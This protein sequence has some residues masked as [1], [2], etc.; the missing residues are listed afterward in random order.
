[1]VARDVT[2]RKHAEQEM[3]LNQRRLQSLLRISQYESKDV[4]ELLDYALDEALA[5]T[6]STIGWFGSYDEKT[7]T[8]TIQAWSKSVIESCGLRAKPTVF[9][10]ENAGIWAEGIRGRQPFILN[11]YQRPNPNKKG[12][13][14]GHAELTRFL[15]VPF[16]SGGRIVA[17]A[18]VANKDS[19]YDESD[20]RQLALLTDSLW[21]IARAR[22]LEEVQRRLSTAIEQAA[23]GVIITD[24]EG[25]IQYVN[26]AL[27]RMTGY[28][29]E[30][31]LGNTPRI[32][33]SGEHD[34]LFYRQLW[35]TINTGKIWAG[36]FINRMKD[37]QLYHQDV[38]ISPVKDASGT[39]INFV[40]VKRDI[41]EQLE[42]SKQLLRAQKL[43][44]VGTLAGGVAHDFNNILQV[45]LG[46]S[47]LMLEDEVL[48]ERYRADLRKIHESASRGADLVQRLLVFSRRRETK[49]ELLDLNS[50]ISEMRKMLE[51]TLPKMIEIQLVLAE[52]LARINADPTQVDQV[53]MNLAVNARDAMPDGGKLI[54]ETANIT[55]DEEYSRTHLEV[56]LGPYVV[57][58]ITDT[59]AG[60]DEATLE[61]IFEPFYTTKETGKGTGLGLAMVHGIV[62]QHGGHIECYSEPGAGTTFKIYFPALVS[63]EEPEEK[64]AGPLPHGGSETILLVDD[65]EMIL[66]LC[67]RILSKAGY[68][69]ITASNGKEALELYQA[70]SDEI[71]LVILD[72]IMPE[73]GGKR[74]LAELLSLDP[75]AKVV[76]ATGFSAEGPTKDAL[77]AG[78]KGF[79]N[80]PYIIRQLL[81]MVREVLDR[82]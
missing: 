65:E 34:T 46:Y 79:V 28:T 41:T 15:I 71:A 70:R 55:L 24:V 6:R 4:K 25:T 77:A 42:L 20:A 47:E 30:E 72:L 31:L 57:L 23:E 3:Q 36:R 75:S 9:P 14:E 82:G 56:K 48:P 81:E 22:R 54:I 33:K 73:M 40:A 69:V 63:D 61:H 11:D 80:K 1:V 62:Q 13:P 43:E 16:L 27:E 12:Y 29:R 51:R 59:G 45:T 17:V 53:L 68:R 18:A 7:E 35:D 10:L 50:R 39:T 44:A 67:S 76:I 8:M 74:C 2:D 49:A 60:M 58:I 37:G 52:G 78:A 38:T 5:L 64:V 26:P 32:M 21:R 66:D 19:D